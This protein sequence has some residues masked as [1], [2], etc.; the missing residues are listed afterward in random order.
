MIRCCSA[1][2]FF[3]CYLRRS[4]AN[5]TRSMELHRWTSQSAACRL[6]ILS[7]FSF[8]S[9]FLFNEIHFHAFEEEGRGTF[10]PLMMCCVIKDHANN[11]NNG[12]HMIKKITFSLHITFKYVTVQYAHIF[13][14]VA[15]NRFKY[16]NRFPFIMTRSKNFFVTKYNLKEK[17]C[18]KY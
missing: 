10:V 8:L 6:V 4:H 18:Q 11:N 9:F 14:W 16:L 7:G 13:W 17:K 3:Y 15:E 2:L 12:C 1:P 5:R